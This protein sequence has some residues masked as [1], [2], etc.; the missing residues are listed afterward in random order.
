M[1]DRHSTDEN[2]L[3]DAA[4][5]MSEGFTGTSVD[6]EQTS[7]SQVMGGQVHMKDSAAK[8]VQASAL[9][10]VDSA[11]AMVR[12]SSIDVDEGAIGV[13][14]S[15]VAS[16]RDSS[17]LVVLARQV[18]AEDVRTLMLISP[19]VDGNVETVFTPLTALAAGAGLAFGI[20]TFASTFAWIVL[21]PIR[22]LRN[23]RS[24]N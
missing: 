11:A 7:K 19:K 18:K 15:S 2:P 16:L 6:I 1:S 24:A 8:S 14:V 13:S 21:R 20:V 4:A 9:H 22:F 23:R 12:S 5:A 17:S 3:E 10:M